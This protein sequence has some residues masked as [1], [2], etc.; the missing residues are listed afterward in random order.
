MNQDANPTDSGRPQM[1]KKEE[2]KN[3]I[4]DALRS[5]RLIPLAVSSFPI[6]VNSCPFVVVFVLSPA[7][8]QSLAG[9]FFGTLS[10]AERAQ[11]E[12]VIVFLAGY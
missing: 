2:E 5:V 7:K 6:R 12:A 8:G 1:R 11:T 10:G 4:N 3:R 9:E